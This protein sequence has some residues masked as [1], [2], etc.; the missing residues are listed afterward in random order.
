MKWFMRTVCKRWRSPAFFCCTALLLSNCT[1][2]DEESLFKDVACPEIIEPVSY[3]AFVEPLLEKRCVSCHNSTF[4]SGNV[5]LED[6]GKL[7]V[8]I[9]NGK[10]LGAIRHTP[11]FSPMPQGE[12]KLADCDIEKIENWIDQAYPEN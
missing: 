2:D 12:S 6:Y 11:G 4:P 9:E 1:F 5:N 10:F 8:H 7:I 3:S